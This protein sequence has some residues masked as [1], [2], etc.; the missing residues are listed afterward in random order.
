MI[1]HLYMC[2]LLLSERDGTAPSGGASSSSASS[3]AKAG[4]SGLPY[5]Y[6]AASADRRTRTAARDEVIALQAAKL[7]HYEAWTA[8]SGLVPPGRGRGPA[9]Q[10]SQAAAQ[11]AEARG[12][13]AAQ[14]EAGWSSL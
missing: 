10:Q 9:V 12:A 7:A 6:E 14:R 11:A 2:A 8:A 5:E 3:Q 13:L 4:T 1:A